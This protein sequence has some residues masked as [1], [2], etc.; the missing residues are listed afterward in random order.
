MGEILWMILLLS[1]PYP[2][3]NI[4]VSQVAMFN[5][6]CLIFNLFC[7]TQRNFPCPNSF[8]SVKYKNPKIV[9]NITRPPPLRHSVPQSCLIMG[10]GN[11]YFLVELQRKR[12]VI[13]SKAKHR[14]LS[15][16]GHCNVISLYS[17]PLYEIKNAE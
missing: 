3:T 7:L 5:G 15:R 4:D 17:K 9:P 11:W 14:D 8:F 13:P 16:R 12:E 6:R 10:Q 2:K 1:M